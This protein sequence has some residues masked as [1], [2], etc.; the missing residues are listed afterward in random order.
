M[1][2]IYIFQQFICAILYLPCI[3]FLK[4]FTANAAVLRR[5]QQGATGHSSLSSCYS[6]IL[7]ATWESKKLQPAF[8]SSF[9][10]S[11]E[12]TNRLVTHYHFLFIKNLHYQE[13]HYQ[14]FNI[15]SEIAF[16]YIEITSLQET[17]FIC[18]FSC[19]YFYLAPLKT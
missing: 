13:F 10:S 5:D 14:D 16:I 17:R 4:F 6:L 19:K 15:I 11:S 18:N 12:R 8:L 7:P 3:N 2:L 9:R 1:Y